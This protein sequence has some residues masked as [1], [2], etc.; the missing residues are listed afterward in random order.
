LFVPV[1]QTTSAVRG[2]PQAKRFIQDTLNNGQSNKW[3]PTK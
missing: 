3:L 2:R 1:D